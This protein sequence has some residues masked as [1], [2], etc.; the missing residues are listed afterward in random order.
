[1]N[2]SI[3]T[4]I[5]GLLIG[6]TIT[7]FLTGLKNNPSQGKIL[8]GQTYGGVATPD[9]LITIEVELRQKAVR[10]LNIGVISFVILIC[11]LI[12]RWF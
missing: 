4:I 12:E 9:K 8:Q 6:L 1:M 10:Y 11:V 5:I 7:G 2:I 3:D